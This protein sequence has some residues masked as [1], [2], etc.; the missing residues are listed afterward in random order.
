MFLFKLAAR[1][2]WRV[3]ML[4]GAVVSCGQVVLPDSEMATASPLSSLKP[5]SNHRL[6]SLCRP[7]GRHAIFNRV[8]IGAW[9]SDACRLERD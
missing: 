1:F 6:S 8:S 7:T 5:A 3:L 9:L 2:D 4:A